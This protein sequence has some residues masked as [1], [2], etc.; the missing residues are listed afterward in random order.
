[1]RDGTRGTAQAA[2]ELIK[3]DRRL[4]AAGSARRDRLGRIP[5][6]SRSASSTTGLA[7]TAGR[8]RAAGRSVQDAVE[9][10]LAEIA[11]GTVATTCAGRTDA[12][13]PCP[14]PGHPLRHERRAAA[15]RLGVRG[16]NRFLPPAIAV[17]WA[18][19]VPDDFNARYAA[20]RTAI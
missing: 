8:P 16:A 7:S 17:R 19:S 1:M 2:V 11:G 6:A 4:N 12:G 20:R 14:R 18:R 15:D 5:C 10:A 13:V 9:R 3:A